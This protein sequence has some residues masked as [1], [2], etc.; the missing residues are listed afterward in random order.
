[1]SENHIWNGY[2]PRDLSTHP[3]DGAHIEMMFDNGRSFSGHYSQELGM[4]SHTYLIP[5][6][7]AILGKK[8]RVLEKD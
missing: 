1:M 7:T 2:D 4:F 8:W 6:E 5:E 3:P